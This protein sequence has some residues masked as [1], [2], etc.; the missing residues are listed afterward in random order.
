MVVTRLLRRKFKRFGSKRPTPCH[1]TD[2]QVIADV[3]VLK[4]CFRQPYR[5]SAFKK[6]CKSEVWFLSMKKRKIELRIRDVRCCEFRFFKSGVSK[7][8]TA[9]VRVEEIG[10]TKIRSH[11]ARSASRSRADIRSRQVCIIE[12]RAIKRSST[13]LGSGK[14]N[15]GEVDITGINSYQT[16]TTH[17]QPFKQHDW[18][19]VRS[20]F[21]GFA[22]SVPNSLKPLKSHYEESRF[23]HQ[24]LCTSHFPVLKVLV[25]GDQYSER[26]KCYSERLEPTQRCPYCVKEPDREFKQ[27]KNCFLHEQPF[28]KSGFLRQ[29]AADALPRLGG[30]LRRRP[31]DDPRYCRSSPGLVARPRHVNGPRR[32]EGR[33]V[34]LAG[35]PDLSISNHHGA[36]R[37]VIKACRNVS[38]TN[39]PLGRGP[40][41][42]NTPSCGKGPRTDNHGRLGQPGSRPRHP[43]RG[44]IRVGRVTTWSRSGAARVEHECS[45]ANSTVRSP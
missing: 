36:A 24:V 23:P 5:R 21:F 27:L 29:G 34:E 10:S 39:P 40:G 9:E 8:R 18:A 12:R 28:L 33:I 45:T 22:I 42:A 32:Q 41:C 7:I 14:L 43:S 11:E 35:L 30:V 26:R 2:L 17:V 38:H 31:G 6:V 13:Q 20:E 15:S 4:I 25:S 37:V 16:S 44:G 19:L 1:P 3:H